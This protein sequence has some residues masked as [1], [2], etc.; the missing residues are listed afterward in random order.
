MLSGM[1][2]IFA[3]IVAIVLGINGVVLFCDIFSLTESIAF[4]ISATLAFVGLSFTISVLPG[5]LN[6]LYP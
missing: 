1:L 5:V 6:P 4:S 3:S 2:F